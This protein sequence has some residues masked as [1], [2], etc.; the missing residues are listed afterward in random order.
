MIKSDMLQL[1]LLFEADERWLDVVRFEGLY[2]VSDLGRVRS[3]PRMTARGVLGARRGGRDILS[4][5]PSPGGYPR[6]RLSRDGISKCY[7]VHHLVTDAFLGPLP[8]GLCRRHK[9]GIKTDC[10]LVNL[11]FGTPSENMQDAL[12]HGAMNPAKGDDHCRA[13]LT[14]VKVREIRRRWDGGDVSQQAL[15]VEFGVKQPTIQNVVARTTWKH[16]A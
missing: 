16:V 7:L 12:R 13:K 11:E 1:P 5:R 3:L 9:N 4:Y 14:E 2:L 6:V 15:A 8:L 10:R